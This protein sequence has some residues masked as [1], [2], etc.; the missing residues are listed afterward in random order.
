MSI[1]VAIA[2]LCPPKAD[3]TPRHEQDFVN[4][5][6]RLDFRQA[7]AVRNEARVL[8]RSGGGTEGEFLAVLAEAYILQGVESW[9]LVDDRN[10]PLAP[11]RDN[12]R[13][14]LMADYDE[15]EKVA[16]AADDLYS[17]AVVLPL[18]GAGPTSSPASPTPASTSAKTST[19]S[20]ARKPSSRSSISTI[21]TDGTVTTS[22]PLVG[23][24][25][26]S[27]NSASVA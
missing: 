23:V 3:G 11:T 9:S 18:L 27:E 15:A 24:Y 19:G 5:R 12:L 4:L 20:K 25:S 1:P 14:V 17:E 2:C 7:V 21:P 22:G 13:A 26:S 8:V 6:E 16:N 10:K